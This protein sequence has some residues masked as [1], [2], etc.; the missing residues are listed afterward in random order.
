LGSLIKVSFL[1]KVPFISNKR[2]FLQLSFGE[3]LVIALLLPGL[4]GGFCARFFLLGYAFSRS[5]S[6]F[7]CLGRGVLTKLDPV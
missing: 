2:H 4:G 3:E 7:L 1:Q 5:G 6:I